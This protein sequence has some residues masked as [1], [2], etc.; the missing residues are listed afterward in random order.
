MSGV[1]ELVGGVQCMIVPA[2]CVSELWCGGDVC[3][4]LQ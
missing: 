2:V 1:G 3:Q 4:S